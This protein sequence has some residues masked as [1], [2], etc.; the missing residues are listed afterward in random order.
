MFR[1][2]ASGAF[3]IFAVVS[4]EALVDGSLPA[5]KCT[6]GMNTC[7]PK[8]YCGA[9]GC[10]DCAKTDPCDGFDLQTIAAT[11]RDDACAVRETIALLP[12]AR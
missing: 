11:E 9:G 2:L 1:R 3:V 8:Q 7:P 12:L 6:P 5:W 10:V 4:C